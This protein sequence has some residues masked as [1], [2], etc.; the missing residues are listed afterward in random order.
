MSSTRAVVSGNL[1]PL[2]EAHLNELLQWRNHPSVRQHMYTQ[3]K[4]TQSEHH[5]WY[6][7]IVSSN[8][9]VALLFLRDNAPSGFVQFRMDSGNFSAMWGFYVAPNCPKGTGLAL[10]QSALT[11]ARKQLRVS[12]VRGEVLEGNIASQN[13]HKK[14]NFQM[15]GEKTITRGR[16]A[17]TVQQYL[18]N[19]KQSESVSKLGEMQ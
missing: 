19:L 9:K 3:H 7:S 6:Q 11:Y 12:V 5:A 1:V 16:S 17:Y 4:I 15:C 8:D 14:L 10:G 2:E 13:F 18:N